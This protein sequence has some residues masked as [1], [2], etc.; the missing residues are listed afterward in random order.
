MNSINENFKQWF[1]SPLLILVFSTILSAGVGNPNLSAIGQVIGDRT[2]DANS[3]DEG[4]PTLRTG[5]VE[6][7]LDANLNPFLAGLFTLSGSEDGF[8]VEEAYLSL[9]KGLPWGLGLKAGKYRL[10]FGKMNGIHPHALPFINPSRAWTSLM[11]G[12]EEGFNET[13]FEV[14]DLLPTPGDWASTLS[15]EVIQG[16]SFHPDSK[17]NRLGWMGRWS[18]SFLLGEVGAIDLGFSGA[19]GVDDIDENQQGGILGVDCKTKF[20]LAQSSQLTVQ[21]EGLFRNSHPRDSLLGLS[22]ENRSGFYAMA[23]YRYHTQIN[24]GLFYEQWEREGT[25]T[26]QDRSFRVFA[27]YAVLEE[28]TILRLAYERYLP[29]AATEVNIVSLQI[30]FSMGPHKAHVF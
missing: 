2:D 9:V 23:D 16:N 24:A 14:S 4:Q 3:A 29:E 10:G 26:F 20:Y 7:V 21:A 17:K 28:S 1:I 30:L 13:A 6:V 11:P 12:G 18:N 25:T 19:T 8:V 22:A 15:A 5:E 27:G